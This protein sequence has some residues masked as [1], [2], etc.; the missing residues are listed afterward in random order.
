MDIELKFGLFK[1]VANSKIGLAELL[2][3]FDACG[4]GEPLSEVDKQ[5]A[6]YKT[7]A[8][9]YPEL[10]SISLFSRLQNNKE[11]TIDQIKS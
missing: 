7:I 6:F 8:P 5:S 3:N 10:K 11:L 1:I 9:V 4:S 2:A